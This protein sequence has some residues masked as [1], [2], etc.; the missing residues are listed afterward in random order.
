MILNYIIKSRDGE[1]TT[2][3]GN[4]FQILMD[5]ESESIHPLWLVSGGYREW[6]RVTFE[7]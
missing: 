5:E 2:S 1:I 3:S 4:L 7:L 6:P